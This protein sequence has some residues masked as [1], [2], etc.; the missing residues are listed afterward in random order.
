MTD[1]SPTTLSPSQA[2]AGEDD[3]VIFWKIKDWDFIHRIIDY[4]GMPRY[5]TVNYTT[6]FRMKRD[7]PKYTVLLEGEQKGFYRISR[8]CQ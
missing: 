5:F 3:M 2:T 1:S 4:F 8:K 7:D 6:P